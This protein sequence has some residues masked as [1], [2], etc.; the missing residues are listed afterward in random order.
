MIRAEDL[1]IGDW[2]GYL[3]TWKDE[4][5]SIQ[6]EGN[7]NNPVI[8]KVE[9]LCGSSAQLYNGEDYFDAEEIELYPLPLTAEILDKNGFS[10]DPL[11]G[12]IFIFHEKSGEVRY[13]EYGPKYYGLTIDNQLATIQDLKIKYVHE[14]QHA[15]RL[16]RIEKE[17]KL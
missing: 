12:H 1:M 14:L 7:P 2:V 11:N 16:C 13:Y 17:I 8:C 15:L 5:G 10:Q 9:M 6:R 4:D 3:P